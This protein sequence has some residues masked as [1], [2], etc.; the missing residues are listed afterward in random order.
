MWFLNYIVEWLNSVTGYFYDAYQEVIG[1]VWPFYLLYL[2]LYFLYRAFAYIT[3]WFGQFN[4]WLDWAA[5]RID[6]ILSSWDIWSYFKPWFG[7][8][9]DA[10]NW[11][12][13]AFLNV[14]HIVENWWSEAQYIVQGWI[15]D[16]S[17]WLQEL[18]AAS[19]RGLAFLRES[20]QWFF[21]NML[22]INEII[23][24]WKDWLGKIAA[25]LIRWGFATLLDVTGL[26]ASAFLEREGF[27]AGWQDFR[28]KVADF[29]TDPLEF[30]WTLFADWFLGPE[31]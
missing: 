23:Q 6:A 4:E 29:F 17:N 15:A 24:W 25:A 2:P 5:G 21:D 16:A 12:A 19:E 18:I 26:I 10:W 22:T 1:W 27:W 28:G 7:Y 9:T 8:A 11:V 3:Y 13:N 20:I 14:W 31:E 30:L